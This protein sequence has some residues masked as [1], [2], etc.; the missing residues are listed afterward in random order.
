VG[1]AR[2]LL[3]ETEDTARFENTRAA[4][5]Y[6][7]AASSVPHR[8]V[9]ERPRERREVAEAYYRLG[10]IDSRVGRTFWLS[11][12]KFFL[13]AA[14]RLAPGAAFAE[15]AYELLE[16]FVVSGYTGSSGVHLPEDEKARLEALRGLIDRS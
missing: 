10:I 8:F 4:L 2:A 3:R 15:K 11:G 9:A 6:Y 7:I 5:V 1:Q 12:T 16:E 13:E 14:I